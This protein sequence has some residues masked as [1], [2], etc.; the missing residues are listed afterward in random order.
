L[1]YTFNTTKL[2]ANNCVSVEPV[3]F[4]S[5][6]GTCDSSSSIMQ[7]NPLKK[8]YTNKLMHSCTCCREVATTKKD[9][10]MKCSDGS[11][12]KQAITLIEKC[13]C[14]AVECKEWGKR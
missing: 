4:T 5:C 9:V 13:G 1:K 6:G 2:Y 14:Q 10:L 8:L 7:Q 12:M 3:E 11:I